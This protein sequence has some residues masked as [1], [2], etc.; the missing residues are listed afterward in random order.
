MSFLDNLENN[1]KA[2]EGRE[3][4]SA[5]NE[6]ASRRRDAERRDALAVAPHAERLK[7]GAFTAELLSAATLAGYS[8]RTKVHFTWLGT[9]LRLDAR[10]RRLELRPT[11]DGVTA[12]FLEGG[13]EVRT[14]PADLDGSPAALVRELL[15]MPGD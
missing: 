1:L 6:Q 15:G 3:D 13:Q 7:S 5:G 14:T 11:A 8:M 12:V 10:N 9:T 2:L 4:A